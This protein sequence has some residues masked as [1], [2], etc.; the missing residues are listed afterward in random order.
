MAVTAESRLQKRSDDPGPARS[1]VQIDCG[2]ESLALVDN[3]D[4]AKTG[5]VHL[6]RCRM[7]KPS[8]S[9]GVVDWWETSAKIDAKNMF[10]LKNQKIVDL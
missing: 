4:L 2:L 5:I 7:S 6:E 9:F 1:S 10:R 8:C 3:R